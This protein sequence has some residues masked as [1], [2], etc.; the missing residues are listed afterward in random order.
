MIVEVIHVLKFFEVSG[1]KN[2]AQPFCLDFSD[3]RDYK[4]NEHCIKDGLLKNG[5]IYGRNSSGK[6]NF[7]LAVFDIVAHLTGN[8]VSPGLYGN[9][10]NAGNGN[11][12]A[13]FR[14]VFQFGN[15][16]VTYIYTKKS[17]N[18]LLVEQLLVNGELLFDCE[19]GDK[20]EDF[21]FITP[22]DNKLFAVDLNFSFYTNGSALRYA[23]NNTIL[24][25]E[26]P[27]YKMMFYVSRMLWFRSI[28]GNTYVG[29][30]NNDDDY[31][32]LLIDDTNARHEFQELL[33]IAGVKDRKLSVVAGPDGK[34]Q[35]YLRITRNASQGRILF[36]EAASSGTKALYNFFYWYKTAPDISLMFID[37]FDAYYH[38][39]LSEIMVNLLSKLPNTQVLL[40]SHNTNLLTNNI[41][42]PDCLFVLTHEKLTSFTNA[43]H[44]ELREGHNLERLYMGGEFNG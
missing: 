38:F 18:A 4:F 42:R 19:Y 10:L 20:P 40:T 37:E 5:I 24:S 9:Y 28:D 29:Y 8:N 39:E 1:F 35:L 41:L 3:V 11:N 21:A 31:F 15:D 44:R 33:E 12:G 26:H 30:K 23:L 22:V 17:N 36:F 25:E 16:E 2:F 13:K 34:K 6:S 7:S 27:L 14:Y 43:T 32:N